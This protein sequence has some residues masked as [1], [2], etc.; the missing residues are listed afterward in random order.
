MHRS[1]PALVAALQQANWRCLSICD[2]REIGDRP[3]ILDEMSRGTKVLHAESQ[4]RIAWA[5]TF[6]PRSFETPGFTERVIAAL[7]RDFNEDAIAVKIWKTVGMGHPFEVR[8][9]SN[10]G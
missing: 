2:S 10:A 9:I 3:S 7:Q 8:P 4:G 6:D 1:A 5:T